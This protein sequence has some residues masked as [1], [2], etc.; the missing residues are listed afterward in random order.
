MS[1]LV[2]DNTTFNMSS[3]EINS[4]APYDSATSEN[5]LIEHTYTIDAQRYEFMVSAQTYTNAKYSEF[6]AILD[7]VGG[8]DSIIFDI[9][10]FGNAMLPY[11]GTQTNDLYTSGTAAAGATT[12]TY[13][14]TSGNSGGQQPN[15]LLAVGSFI[16]ISGQPKIYKIR[17]VDSTNHVYGIYPSLREAVSTDTQ[18]LY[19]TD[20]KPRVKMNTEVFSSSSSSNIPELRNYNFLLVENPF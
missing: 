16:Q 9:T 18:I 3:L 14:N 8:F 15:G 19:D 2:I 1:N 7:Q 12:L 20:V 13:D 11:N 5:S 4:N 10:S 17:S 6:T